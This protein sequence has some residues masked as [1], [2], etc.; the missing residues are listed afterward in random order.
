MTEP[1]QKPPKKYIQLGGTGDRIWTNQGPIEI[2]DETL[3]ECPVCDGSATG[4]HNF[5]VIR[6]NYQSATVMCPNCGETK[7]MFANDVK[8]KP[9]AAP[10]AT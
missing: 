8:R 1:D 4:P 9:K 3:D 7:T 5:A 6:Q 2:L 10:E